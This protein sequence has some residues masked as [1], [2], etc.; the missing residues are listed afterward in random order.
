MLAPGLAYEICA[1]GVGNTTLS[2][3]M[4]PRCMMRDMLQSYF[5]LYV[6]FQGMFDL[7]ELRY[8]E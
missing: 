6:G 5:R 1:V 7:R 8:G 3:S 4:E 2:A